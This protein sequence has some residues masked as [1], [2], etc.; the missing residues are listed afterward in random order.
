MVHRPD[1]PRGREEVEHQTDGQGLGQP[2]ITALGLHDPADD[3]SSEGEQGDPDNDY[4]DR[5]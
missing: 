1:L 4:D 2:R 3:A 5:V